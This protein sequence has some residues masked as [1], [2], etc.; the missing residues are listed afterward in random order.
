LR[1][2]ERERE[3][4]VLEILLG[5]LLFGEHVLIQLTLMS[6]LGYLALLDEVILV[7]LDFSGLKGHFI[8]DLVLLLDGVALLVFEL[9]LKSLY[10]EFV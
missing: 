8:Y 7:P 9:I 6:S 1:L 10:S 3:V 5:A 2:P 4:D